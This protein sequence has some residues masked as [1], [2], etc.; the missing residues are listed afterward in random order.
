[1]VS[2]ITLSI[3]MDP[4]DSVIMRFQY[5]SKVLE[6]ESSLLFPWSF[7]LLISIDRHGWVLG[8]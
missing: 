4:K 7:F 5:I 8:G 3:A 1:M 2:F 6:S